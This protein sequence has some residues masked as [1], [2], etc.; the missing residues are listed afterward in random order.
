MPALLERPKMTRAMYEALKR[1]I[2]LEREKKKQ[3]QEQDA[4]M[5]RLKKERELRKKKE[6]E[7]SLTLEQTNEQIAHLQDKLEM[8]KKQ[9][10]ELFMQLKRV[11]YQE[12]ETRR[13]VQQKEQSEL[14]VMQPPFHLT[15]LPNVRQPAVAHGRPS[16]YKPT[17][18]APSMSGLKRS[19]SP[20]S[21]PSSSHYQIYCHS[22]PKYHPSID[23]KYARLDPKFVHSDAKYLTSVV[24]A[25]PG[26]SGYLFPAQH[27]QAGD[28]KSSAFPQTGMNHL[29]TTSAAYQPQ[30]A[31][32]AVSSYPSSHSNSSKYISASQSAFTSYQSP[33]AQTHSK[34]S[35]AE[36]FSAAYSVQRLPQPAYHA[37]LQLPL[38]HSASKQSAIEEK[39][40][41][42]QGQI[43][44][45]V[46]TQQP[47]LVAHAIQL[48]QQQQQQTKNTYPGQSSGQVK[49]GYGNQAHGRF[50]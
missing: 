44:G 12:D 47:A 18:S 26:Q 25:K 22:E 35:I 3:A 39:Y 14:V 1:H 38:D 49:P 4:M 9:K 33:F 13:K 24:S 37:S 31:A 5:E 21:P 40:K 32:V 34:K 46:V 29:F 16:L 45:M 11:L 48:Q 28:Y 42:G 23:G 10:S 50:F 8:L 27:T 17:A 2:M 41:L 15:S 30:T 7:D 36:Q 6:E 19:R 20:S 43:R